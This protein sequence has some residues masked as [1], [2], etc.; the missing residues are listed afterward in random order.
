MTPGTVTPN[1]ATFDK[2][3]SS[4]DYKDVEV[5]VS[6]GEFEGLYKSG[7][8]VANTNYT[9][10][11]GAL[12]IKKEYLA[13]LATGSVVLSVHTDDGNADL[14]ITVTDTTPA[15]INPTTATFDKNT[16]GENYGDVE[17]TVS[18]G[19]VTGVANGD[20]ALEDTS[21]TFSDGTLTIK[22]EYLSTLSTGEVALTI[23]TDNGD[24][25]LTI[26]V[27]DTQ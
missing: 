21:F 19:S 5:T 13:T 2:Y 16:S 8:E 11:A 1:T 18:N 4:T 26:T 12:K 15:S 23:T 17:T 9:F 24:A 3:A 7:T 20:T 25:T 22:K 10:S 6:G 14:T 27:E